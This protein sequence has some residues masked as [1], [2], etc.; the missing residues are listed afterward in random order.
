MIVTDSTVISSSAFALT[1]ND[2]T[3]RTPIK[4]NGD[5]SSNNLFDILFIIVLLLF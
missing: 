4:N 2:E 3:K 5:I 1:K